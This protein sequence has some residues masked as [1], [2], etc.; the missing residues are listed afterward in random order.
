MLVSSVLI[1]QIPKL[2]LYKNVFSKQ[3]AVCGCMLFK[4]VQRI[5]WY[6]HVF[7]RLSDH[8]SSHKEKSKII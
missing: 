1:D 5:M 2:G 4:N 6:K 7:Q 8:L 3:I